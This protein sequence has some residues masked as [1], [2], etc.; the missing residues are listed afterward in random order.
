MRWINGSQHTGAK[1]QA[2]T[3]A[4]HGR[5]IYIAQSSVAYFCCIVLAAAAA[6]CRLAII[7]V[8]PSI[9]STA[10]QRA[11]IAVPMDTSFSFVAFTTTQHFSWPLL[12]CEFVQHL[13]FDSDIE[14]LCQVSRRD[15]LPSQHTTHTTRGHPVRRAPTADQG[16]IGV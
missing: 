6:F 11:I 15:D 3:V 2:Q 1:A 5:C 4:W 10:A 9:S 7:I 16:I 8:W 13:V 14:P 12:E